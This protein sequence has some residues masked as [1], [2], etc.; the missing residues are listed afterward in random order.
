MPHIIF[1]SS[2]DEDS[3]GETENIIKVGMGK[4]TNLNTRPDANT[5]GPDCDAFRVDTKGRH[6]T[7]EKVAKFLDEADV[8]CRIALLPWHMTGLQR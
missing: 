1:D 6:S 8:K 7:D 5:A 3:V 4:A 2:D